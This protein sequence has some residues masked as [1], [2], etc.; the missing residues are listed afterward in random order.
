[1]Q[2][3]YELLCISVN[4]MDILSWLSKNAT[5]LATCLTAFLT[6]VV[7]SRTFAAGRS[8]KKVDA[9]IFL[10]N[11]ISQLRAAQIELELASKSANEKIE[12]IAFHKNS[13]SR[14]WKENRKRLPKIQQEIQN[15][16]SLITASYLT[17]KEKQKRETLIA[18]AITC[19]SVRQDLIIATQKIAV[20]LPELQSEAGKISSAISLHTS[21]QKWP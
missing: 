9:Q 19:A 4:Q 1:M 8:D 21:P 5:A 10:L 7:A 13:L 11:E 17:L 12:L 6:F 16:E 3:T 14:Q 18:Q 20:I 2:N 15:A